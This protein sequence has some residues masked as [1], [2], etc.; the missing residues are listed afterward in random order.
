MD[1]LRLYQ[2]FGDRL[3]F[4]GGIDV[5]DMGRYDFF[6]NP[7]PFGSAYDISTSEGQDK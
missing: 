6:G 1:L 7:I 2:N 3:S 4:M 5:G